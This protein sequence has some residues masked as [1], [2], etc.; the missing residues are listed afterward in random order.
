MASKQ[1]SD[2]A[3]KQLSMETATVKVTN[4][5]RVAKSKRLPCFPFN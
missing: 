1:L 3:S 4:A 5:Y 2:M